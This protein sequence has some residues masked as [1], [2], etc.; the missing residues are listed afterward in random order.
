MSFQESSTSET[1]QLLPSCFET[2]IG[3]GKGVEILSQ[4]G[5]KLEGQLG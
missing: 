2:R 4:F 5:S 3:P 1:E